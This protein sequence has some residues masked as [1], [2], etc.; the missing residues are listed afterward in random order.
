MNALSPRIL[1]LNPPSRKPVF[2]DCYCSGPCKGT[3]FIHPLDLQ[4]QSGFLIKGNYQVEFIDAVFERLH[5]SRALQRIK[6]FDPDVILSLV[7][8]AY[9]EEDTAFLKQIKSCFPSARL[10][11]TGDIARFHPERLFQ[12]IPEADGLLMDFCSSGLLD[13][14]QGRSS[15]DLLLPRG[16]LKT[17]SL[18][19]PRPTNTLSTPSRGRVLFG[20]TIINYL[21]SLIPDITVLHRASGAPMTVTIATRIY[22]DTEIGGSKISFR[23][24]ILLPPWVLKT[25]TYVM[26][27]SWWKKIVLFVYSRNGKRRDFD[28]NGSVSR[29]PI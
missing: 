15:R 29:D 10:F 24:C 21:F 25:F 18:Q 13:Y 2:R 26:Q 17:I 1:L 28:F 19:T 6:A 5:P 23:S 4:I 12:I 20:N 27:R 14:L 9:L 16:G 3:I 22:W 7:G 11:L 8:K